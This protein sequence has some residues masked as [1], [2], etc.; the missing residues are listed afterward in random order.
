MGPIAAFDPD[1]SRWQMRHV[2]AWAVSGGDAGQLLA[3][4]RRCTDF[5][6]ITGRTDPLS[7]ATAQRRRPFRIGW[8]RGDTCHHDKDD[9]VDVVQLPGFLM[10]TQEPVV[11]T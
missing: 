1:P 8:L 2:P 10:V 5:G 11:K 4:N 7:P 6:A 3:P 9:A